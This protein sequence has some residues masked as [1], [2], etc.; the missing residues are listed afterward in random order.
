MFLFC[1]FC[2]YTFQL[3]LYNFLFFQEQSCLFLEYFSHNIYP[4]FFK[5]FGAMLHSTHHLHR[6]KILQLLHGKLHATF[7]SKIRR[8]TIFYIHFTLGFSTF[9]AIF[10]LHTKTC[11]LSLYVNKFKTG[12]SVYHFDQKMEKSSIKLFMD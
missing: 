6:R 5:I 7:S 1:S 2:L 9:R 10:C 8:Y 12:L 4:Y 3:A 11:K